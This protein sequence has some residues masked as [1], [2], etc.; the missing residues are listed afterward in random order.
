MSILAIKNVCVVGSGFIGGQIGLQCAVHGYRVWMHDVSDTALR[1]CQDDQASM[2]DEQIAAHVVSAN[3][4]QRV[5]NRIQFSDALSEAA[6]AAD[7]VFEAVREELEV[8]RDV[9]RALDEI[10]CPHAILATNC[11]SLRVSRIQSATNRP[12]RC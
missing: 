3:E 2:L 10:C 9:F 7:L 11:S 8:K 12:T 5:L 6:T 1:R 4:R